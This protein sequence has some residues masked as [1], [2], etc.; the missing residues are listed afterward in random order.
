MV[1]KAFTMLELVMVMVIMGIV[2]SIGTDIVASLY[3]NYM[4]TRTIERLQSQTEL[5]LDQ[6]AN[7]LQYR[8]KDSVI[9]RKDDGNLGNYRPLPSANA[10]DTILEWIGK[11][12]EG[13]LGE[14]NGT[15]VVPGWSGFIDLD[16]NDTNRTIAPPRVK[17]RGSR[18]DYADNTIIAL[19]D[20]NVSL[21][22]GAAKHPALIFKGKDTYD[23]RD[24]GLG[25]D[26]HNAYTYRVQRNGTDVLE[27]I[28]NIPTDIYEQY[29]LAWSAY[30]I[31]PQ[32]NDVNDFN[33]TMHYNYQPWEN[34]DYTWVTGVLL[35][36]HVSTFKFTQVGDTIRIKLCIRDANRSG[37]D[38]DFAFCKEKVVY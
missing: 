37:S 36:E 20:N 16:S 19:S 4:K 13:V 21:T 10:D 38:L 29:D 7:R 2:A 32:G 15:V 1:R 11:D 26:G 33:L 27:F 14:Y 24:Y 22:A 8:I 23:I 31:V 30:A 3:E 5:V 9:A 12:N 25:N 34:E 6:I 18:L 17:T 28:G 35:V